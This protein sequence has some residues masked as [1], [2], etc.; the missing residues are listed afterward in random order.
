MVKLHCQSTSTEVSQGSILEPGLFLSY[1]NDVKYNILS[2]IKLFA[3]DT[4]LIKEIDK[5]VNDF[6][7][8]N[9]DLGNPKFDRCD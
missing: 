4:A 7:E 5:P 1:A 2:S 6:R 3:D 8:L 9:K